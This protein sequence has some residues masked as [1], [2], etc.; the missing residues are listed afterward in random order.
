MTFEQLKPL[1]RQM[2]PYQLSLAANHLIPYATDEISL[3]TRRWDLL[4]HT[5]RHFYESTD[6]D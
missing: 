1:F 2:S 5:E 3:M 6:D 4:N